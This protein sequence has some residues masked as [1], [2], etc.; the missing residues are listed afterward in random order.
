LGRTFALRATVAYKGAWVRLVRSVCEP[1]IM[2]EAAARFAP[3]VALLP[4][5]AGFAG[6]QSWLIEGCRMAQPLE[7]LMGSRI[8]ESIT[9][10]RGALVSVQASL[11]IDGRTV[12]LGAPALVG[13]LGEAASLL[14]DPLYD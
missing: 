3:A 9:P 6:F 13:R 14:V 12:L 5:D 2:Q 7:A 10:P 4:S 11:A 8:D 1:A